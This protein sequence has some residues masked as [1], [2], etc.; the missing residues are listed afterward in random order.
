MPM[1]RPTDFVRALSGYFFE[2]LP[3]QKGL[4]ENTIQSYHDSM[5]VFLSYCESER[6]LKREKM[7]IKDLDRKLVEDFLDWLEQEKGN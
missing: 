3:V 1:I 5:S 2:Y 4:S 6:H 7:E